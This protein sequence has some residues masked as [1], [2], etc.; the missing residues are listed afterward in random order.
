MFSRKEAHSVDYIDT[1]RV[2]QSTI[3]NPKEKDMFKKRMLYLVIVIVMV[4]SQ[5]A[6]CKSST[7]GW[8]R[9][10]D[11]RRARR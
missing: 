10:H 5:L 7:G 4:M 2:T 9:W 3:Q 8:R 11:D 1:L 6:A